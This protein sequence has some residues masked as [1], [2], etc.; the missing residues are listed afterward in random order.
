MQHKRRNIFFSFFKIAMLLFYLPFF[1]VQ[2]F[3]SY[4]SI[5][6]NKNVEGFYTKSSLKNSVVLQNHANKTSCK[7]STIRLNKRFQPATIPFCVPMSFEI[8]VCI[9]HIKLFADCPDPLLPSF[10]LFT[11]TLR[12]PPAVA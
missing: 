7:L 6:T 8:H 11:Q 5:S 10:H 2:V 1:L 4:D 3:V 9:A 12:G